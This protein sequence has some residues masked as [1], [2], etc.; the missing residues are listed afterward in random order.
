M[1]RVRPNI[2]FFAVRAMQQVYNIDVAKK[3]NSVDVR[4]QMMNVLFVKL[5][6]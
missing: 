4:N 3:I 5:S 2:A 1:S 6:A